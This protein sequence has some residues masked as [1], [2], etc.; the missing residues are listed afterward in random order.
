MFERFAC[1]ISWKHIFPLRKIILSSIIFWK[2]GKEALLPVPGDPIFLLI[3][4]PEELK[5][6]FFTLDVSWVP[7]FSSL[8]HHCFWICCS[9]F[10]HQLL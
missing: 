7:F 4:V 9:N 2:A 1:I 5:P 8:N 10:F 6:V 3:C